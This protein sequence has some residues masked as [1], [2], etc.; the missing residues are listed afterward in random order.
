MSHTTNVNIN[1]TVRIRR[2]QR[3]NTEHFLEHGEGFG[4]NYREEEFFEDEYIPN[5]YPAPTNVRVTH[6][7]G[8]HDGNYDP[9]DYNLNNSASTA[10]SGQQPS[11]PP[12]QQQQFQKPPP[13][14]FA[15][16]TH[17]ND[18]NVRVKV[19]I[20]FD[21]TIA[22]AGGFVTG[23]VEIK[24]EETQQLQELLLNLSGT[25]SIAKTEKSR[26]IVTLYTVLSRQKVCATGKASFPFRFT[27]PDNLPSSFHSSHADVYYKVHATAKFIAGQVDSSKVVHIVENAAHT[28]A[29]S[30][31]SP[32]IVS[33]SGSKSFFLAGSGEVNADV[34]IAKSF[35]K[36][37]EPIIINLLIEN[38]TKKK[39]PF[40][41]IQLVRLIT[42]G[43][44]ADL[45]KVVYS[46]SF[47][48]KNV[49]VDSMESRALILHVEAIPSFNWSVLQTQLFKVHFALNVYLEAGGIVS[50]P[51][52][53]T[54]PI[55]I[56]HGVS[57][58]PTL[59]PSYI[60]PASTGS[61]SDTNGSGIPSSSSR[62]NLSSNQFPETEVPPSYYDSLPAENPT[63][64]RES[65]ILGTSSS[66]QLPLRAPPGAPNP[67]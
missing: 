31:R 29:Q 49:W 46:I 14:N 10:G 51:L 60:D 23:M 61:S 36:T 24:C 19:E 62:N 32:N 26:S 57:C 20:L 43:S 63:A 11:Q 18:Q 6:T 5:Y 59:I 3:A 22:V 65:I 67:N 12:S 47:N 52:K 45:E 1:N 53:L 15:Y 37:G 27:L 7:V 55:R 56:A 44:A 64:P 4:E 35:F 58:Q 17:T 28:F 39:V 33:A 21:H 30:T 13:Q 16:S 2:P 38:H 8:V 25:E 50:K 66:L 54:L 42:I 41:K 40:I 9:N 48:D 34:S